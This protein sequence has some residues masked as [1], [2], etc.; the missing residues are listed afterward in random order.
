VA[1]AIAKIKIRTFR[2]SGS[3]GYQDGRKNWGA[4]RVRGV[5]DA[6]RILKEFGI[7]TLTRRIADDASASPCQG[8]ARI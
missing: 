5:G 6:E 8:E 3:I 1:I 4:K 2:A 7:R